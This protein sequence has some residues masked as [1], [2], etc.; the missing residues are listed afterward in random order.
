M[1]TPRGVHDVH[2]WRIALDACVPDAAAW[3]ILSHAERKRAL[4][5]RAAADRARYV[6][7]HVALRTILARYVESAPADL[8]FRAGPHGKPALG[9]REWGRVEFNLA[10]SGAFALLAVSCHGPVGIDVIRWDDTADHRG[11]A[12]RYFSASERATLR[13]LRGSRARF[14][15]AFYTAW[16]RKEAYLKA[17]G[18]GLSEGLAHFD[19]TLHPDDAA[20]VLRDRR[21]AAAPA[22]WSVAS[23]PMPAGYSAGIVAV[24]PLGEL[25]LVDVHWTMNG[26]SFHATDASANPKSTS[27]T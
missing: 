25:R 3:A 14:V 20:A 2:V 15:H 11:V 7:A 4:A 24:A 22:R 19:V 6:E 17:T 13:S 18:S 12:E 5:F 16:C 8:A 21:D 1:S 27:A 26:A 10:H 9:S 23:L